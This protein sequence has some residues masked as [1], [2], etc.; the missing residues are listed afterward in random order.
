[1]AARSLRLALNILD[2]NDNPRKARVCRRE[3]D[4]LESYSENELRSWYRFAR[5]G[6]QFII[7]LLSDEI[8]PAARRSHSLLAKNESFGYVTILGV[9][10][11]S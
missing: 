1:M 8:A 4:P 6:L 2:H 9:G 11:F 5:E 3:I 7:D 10:K